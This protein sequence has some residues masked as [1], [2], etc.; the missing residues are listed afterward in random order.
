VTGGK[1][2]Y[3]LWAVPLDGDRR[4][5]PLADGPHNEVHGNVSPDGR[6]LAYVSDESG[7]YEVYIQGFPKPETAPRTPVSVGGGLQPRWS[8][9]G[10]EL[11]YLRS[12]GMLMSVAV[13]TNGGLELG[14]T[15]PLFMTELPTTMTAYRSDYVP[16]PDGTRFLM[17]LP[18]PGSAP[19]SI[20]VVVNWLALLP[21]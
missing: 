18:V 21:R 1:G 3:D 17:K 9:R 2:N 11:F 13:R 20:T 6:W 16:A 7:R 5:V 10:N 12:D 15:M 8:P 14:K 19:P 4:P